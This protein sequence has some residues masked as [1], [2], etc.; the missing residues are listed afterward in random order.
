MKH[1]LLFPL[2]FL[3][4]NFIFA[5]S[6]EGGVFKF[7]AF[8]TSLWNPN[9]KSEIEWTKTDFLVVLNYDSRKLNTY[10][11]E[12]KDINLIKDKNDYIDK[13]GSQ[14]ISYIGIDESGKKCTVSIEI[15]KKSGE[16]YHIA[17]LFIDYPEFTLTFRLK[18]NT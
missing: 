16:D 1:A 7:K 12:E 18:K 6:N 4:L 2:L 10:G 3:S 8:E 9:S 5:Q 15:F 13:D 11:K 14:W 17:T